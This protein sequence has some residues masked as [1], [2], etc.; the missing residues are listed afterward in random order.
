MNAGSREM[1]R[2]SKRK[3]MKALARI[4]PHRQTNLANVMECIREEHEHV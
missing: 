2:E 1:S 4:P 3:K